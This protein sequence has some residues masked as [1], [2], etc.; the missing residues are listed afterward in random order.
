[1]IFKEVA[2]SPKMSPFGVLQNVLPTG[3]WQLLTDLTTLDDLPRLTTATFIG[4]MIAI[5]GNILISLA[6]NLQK[7]A[8]KR[9]ETRKRQNEISRNGKDM[10]EDILQHRRFEDPSLNEADEDH[11]EINTR[12]NST[13]GQSSLHVETQ[14]LIPFPDTLTPRDYGTRTIHTPSPMPQLRSVSTGGHTLASRSKKLTDDEH[15]VQVDV[16]SQEDRR[17]NGH[18]PNTHSPDV[19]EQGNESDYLKSKLWWLGFLLM[20]VGETGNFISYAWAP[21]SVV[22]PL[23]TF[24]LMA[25]CLF[26]PLMLGECF[27]KRDLLGIL[28]AIIGAVTVVL[29]SNASDIRLNP[30]ALVRA[31]SQTPFIIY[32][33]IYIIGAV[34]LA[35]LSH[36]NIGRQWVFVDVGLCA[37][38]GGFTVLSTKAVSTLLTM[39]WMDMF[40]EWI[41]YPIAAVLVFTGVGQIKYLNRALMRFDSKVVIPVQFVLFTLSAIIGSAILYG[42]FKTAKFHQIV[43]FLYG[44]A[45]TFLG[46]FIIAWAPNTPN[47]EETEHETPEETAIIN[48]RLPLTNEEA[49]PGLGSLGR[50]RRATLIIPSSVHSPILRQQSAVSLIGL[51]PAQHLLLVHTPPR[52]VPITRRLREGDTERG[53]WGPEST[54]RRRTMSWLGEDTRGSPAGTRDSSTGGRLRNGAGVHVGS[55][56][57]NA[58]H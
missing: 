6:L 7:L 35:T 51:S 46:V 38:F 4:I 22:A 49:R 29:A 24:A 26:A 57:Q 28:I 15:V 25:N 13:S 43:T 12:E 9:V 56:D 14:S 53:N 50:R 1:M 47:Q 19:L 30:A 5:T 11:L 23:G 20:N 34:V 10:N 40:T 36:G 39:E 32:S 18:K 33:C 48:G 44:C 8:H 42:D 55:L 41:T 54:G 52:E 21:A 16:I 27:R 58:L 17:S 31:I 3:E 37:L 2:V 45:A